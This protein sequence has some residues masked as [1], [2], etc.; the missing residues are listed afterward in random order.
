MNLLRAWL[1]YNK[2]SV[3]TLSETWLNSNISDNEIKLDNY[4]LYRADRG[5]RGG[6]VVTYVSSYLFSELVI[7]N[8]KPMY[9]EC[10]FVCFL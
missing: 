5:A 4:V 9:F 7:P 3:I 6:G 10:L 1:V 2:P 8:E